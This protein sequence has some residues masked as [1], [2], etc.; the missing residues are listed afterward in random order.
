MKKILLML[1]C[2]AFLFTMS[3]CG[4]DS[5]KMEEPS[6]TTSEL[7]QESVDSSITS[8]ELASV[9]SGLAEQSSVLQSKTPANVTSQSTI[10]STGAQTESKNQGNTNSKS[11]QGWMLKIDAD[12]RKEMDKRSSN[13][14]IP[15]YIWRID[16]DRAIITNALVKE[17]KM[18]PAVYED[19]QRYINEIEKVI[20]QDL[21]KSLGY[22]AA[23]KKQADG[24]SPIDWALSNKVD[25]Y[26]MAR[27]EITKR[28]YIAFNSMFI[29]KYIDEK[30]RIIFYKGEVTS[31]IAVQATKSEI[32]RFAKD[33]TVVELSLYEEFIMDTPGPE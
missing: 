16:I 10:K 3:A 4:E 12:L 25:E 15:V 27:L 11:T 17:K 13:D 26:C 24:M 30:N 29:K 22:E 28:E 20:I 23:H 31:T 32:E 9:L 33:E 21:E 1:L 14:L 18:D 7:M 5:A 8:E 19:S 2:L 6:D